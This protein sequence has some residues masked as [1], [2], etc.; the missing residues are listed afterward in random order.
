MLG[1]SLGEGIGATR[2][3]AVS[4]RIRSKSLGTLR[5]RSDQ[6]Y[7]STT[8]DAVAAASAAH[9]SMS[10]LTG[11]TAATGAW[12]SMSYIHL[13]LEASCSVQLQRYRRPQ[14]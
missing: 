3:S 13:L 12:R 14:L 7:S 4:R 2:R 1:G 10:S 8:A 9:G 11:M 5:R 6:R